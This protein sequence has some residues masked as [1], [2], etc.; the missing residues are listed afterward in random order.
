MTTV[1]CDSLLPF[2]YSP[3]IVFG[4]PLFDLL[5]THT[6]TFIRDGIVTYQVVFVVT[7]HLPSNSGCRW[8]R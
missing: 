8:Y 7:F 4:D 1:D 3:V 2:E 6:A 5:V